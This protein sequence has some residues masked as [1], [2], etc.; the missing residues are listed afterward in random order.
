VAA[1]DTGLEDSDER[2]FEIT[3]KT[4]VMIQFTVIVNDP[5]L[6]NFVCFSIHR[7]KIE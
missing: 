5:V 3:A 6:F 4:A 1:L 2:L 7:Y